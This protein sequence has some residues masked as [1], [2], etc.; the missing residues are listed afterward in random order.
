MSLD[1]LRTGGV[2]LG[3]TLISKFLEAKT[4]TLLNTDTREVIKGQFAHEDLSRDVSSRWEEVNALTRE[5]PILQFIYGE[6]EKLEVQ[7]QFFRRDITD[8]T[9]NEKIQKLGSWVKK[10]KNQGRPPILRFAVGDGTSINLQVIL[11]SLSRISYSRPDFQGQIRQVSFNMTLWSYVTSNL[12]D[13]LQTSTRYHRT[14][15]GQYYELIAQAEYGNPML[16][17][18]IRKQDEQVKSPLLVPGDIV[19]LPAIEGVRSSRITQTSVILKGAFGNKPTIQRQRRE[20]ILDE[21]SQPVTLDIN[22]DWMF[23]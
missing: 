3:A 17:D 1:V 21:L 22:G 4:W 23:P 7:S 9:V 14:A 11:K 10:D 5:N 8:D 16:G 20:E 2:A 18:V 19:K 13:E 12:S 6:L 15:R